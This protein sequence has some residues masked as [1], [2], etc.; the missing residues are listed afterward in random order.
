MPPSAVAGPCGSSPSAKRDSPSDPG[1]QFAEIKLLDGRASLVATEVGREDNGADT[2]LKAPAEAS[3]P[4]VSIPLPGISDAAVGGTAFSPHS[5]SMLW[6][7]WET[8]SRTAA[9]RNWIATADCPAAGDL[10]TTATGLAEVAVRCAAPAHAQHS[11][12]R[13][14][15]PLKLH[16]FFA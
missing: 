14:A 9:P 5:T 13:R 11:T 6:S 4:G 3:E 16:S 8:S 10:C 12:C 2:V 15:I 1:G 7:R